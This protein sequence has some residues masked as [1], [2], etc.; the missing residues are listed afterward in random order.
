MLKNLRAEMAREGVTM[1]D[2][3][4]ALG[5]RYATISDKINGKSRFYYDEAVRVKDLFFPDCT[6]EYLFKEYERSDVSSC[7]SLISTNN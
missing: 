4:K 7:Q 2:I 3:S 5:L 6:I 1:V